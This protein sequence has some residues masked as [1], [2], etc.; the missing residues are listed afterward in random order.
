MT[1]ENTPNNKEINGVIKIN[2][3]FIDVLFS[4]LNANYDLLYNV[5]HNLFTIYNKKEN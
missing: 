4:A 5:F 3:P 1:V 2:N